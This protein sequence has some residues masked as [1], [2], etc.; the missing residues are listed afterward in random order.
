MGGKIINNLSSFPVVFVSGKGAVL[1]DSDGKKYIDFVSGI[2]VNCLGHNHPAVVKALKRQVKRE[3]HISNYYNSDTGLRFASRLLELTGFEKVFFGNS[4]AEANE[5]A[6][7][8]ARKWG[9]T[10]AENS[11]LKG[12]SKQVIVTLKK[13]FHGRTVASLTATGQDKFHPGCFGPYPEGFRYIEA[14]DYQALENIIDDSVCAVLIECV[15][16]EGGVNVIDRDWA[17]ALA[18]RARKVNAL[19]MA[20]EVQ[21]GIGRTGVFLASQELGIEPDVVT[22]AKGICAGVPMGAVLMRK[23]AR[24]VFSAGDHQSTFGGNPLACSAGLVVLE[25]VGKK[26]FLDNVS[27]SGEYIRSTI[28]GW[29]LPCIKEIRGRGLMIGVELKNDEKFTAGFVQKTLLEAGLCISTAG[30]YVLR[31]LP[32]LVITKKEIDEG[33]RLLYLVLSQKK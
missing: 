33:L 23:R 16:G 13:S 25:T 32:P 29:N 31:F 12:E 3:I 30:P 18:E 15:Q 2:G 21:T 4:G 6:I 17:L 8:L 27:R 28:K 5:C 26:D 1:K 7:K 19:V 11:G 24:D 9:H 10:F 20:D 22:L 14:G